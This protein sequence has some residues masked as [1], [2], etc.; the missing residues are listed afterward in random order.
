MLPP[1]ETPGNLQ[2][3]K[4]K[5]NPYFMVPTNDKISYKYG[6]ML[7][8]YQHIAVNDPY[9]IASEMDMLSSQYSSVASTIVADKH[10]R[11]ISNSQK[12]ISQINRNFIVKNS[13]SKQKLGR[14]GR[15]VFPKDFFSN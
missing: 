10:R 14:S 15:K 12:S 11:D 6:S 13:S 3:N 4:I 5:K 9:K 8:N 7:N 1:E 2:N